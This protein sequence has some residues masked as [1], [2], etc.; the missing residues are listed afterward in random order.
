[1][2]PKQ[3]LI[4][5]DSKNFTEL[6]VNELKNIPSVRFICHKINGFYTVT[7]KCSSYYKNFSNTYPSSF[8][9]NYIYLYTSTSLLLSELIMSFYEKTLI[10]R[11]LSLNYFYFQNEEQSQIFNIASSLLDPCSPIELSKNLYSKRKEKLLSYLLENF[12]NRNY[13]NIEAFTN[14][15]VPNYMCDIEETIDRAVELFLSNIS[16]IE[17]IQFILENW[18]V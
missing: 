18:L 8:Y 6:F 1:M 3:I 9:G 5:S 2:C 12:R 16:Y 13:I 7:I 4:K 17:L 14:F 11:F 10:K 15:S